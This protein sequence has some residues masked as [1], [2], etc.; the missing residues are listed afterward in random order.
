MA[1][2]QNLTGTH[3]LTPII[4]SHRLSGKVGL[5]LMPLRNSVGRVVYALKT[6]GVL[7]LLIKDYFF[8]PNTRFPFKGM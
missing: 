6:P 1:R 2:S 3:Q 7:L 5:N 4:L 8:P